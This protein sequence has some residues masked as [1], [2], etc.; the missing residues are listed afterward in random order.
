MVDVVVCAWLLCVPVVEP[1]ERFRFVSNLHS[2]CCAAVSYGRRLSS[3]SCAH[4]VPMRLMK[5]WWSFSLR[6]S[7]TP[8]PSI[9]TSAVSSSSWSCLKDSFFRFAWIVWR[10]RM[11]WTI[12]SWKISYADGA[13]SPDVTL[14]GIGIPAGTYS[15]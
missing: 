8:A 3:S 7:S 10:R 11:F 6:I 9:E 5:S 1:R 4:D 15:P 14:I 12:S 2:S 13:L